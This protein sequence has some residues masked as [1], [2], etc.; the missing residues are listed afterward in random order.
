MIKCE[1]FD[2]TLLVPVLIGDG[3]FLYPAA[4]GSK[5]TEQQEREIENKFKDLGDDMKETTELASQQ[6][7]DDKFRVDMEKIANDGITIMG[8]KLA[9]SSQKSVDDAGMNENK[10]YNSDVRNYLKKKIADENDLKLL[11][12]I[13]CANGATS[14][15]VKQ[16][17][18]G[19]DVDDVLKA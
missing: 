10:D 9:S 7:T 3:N 8:S 2:T 13:D 16:I 15:H 19:T 5:I 18:N 1:I 4:N 11:I 17:F 6:T 12:M 14:N